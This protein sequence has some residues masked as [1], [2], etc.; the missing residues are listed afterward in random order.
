MKQVK[1]VELL[2]EG[3]LKL[4]L[5]S[6]KEFD[7]YM[8]Q[9][10]RSNRYALMCERKQKGKTVFYYDVSERLSLQELLRLCV[11]SQ[12]EACTLLEVMMRA[13][14]AAQRELPVYAA[15]DTIFFDPQ[16]Q[17]FAFVVLP[18]HD[19]VY[20]VDWHSLLADI[21][22]DLRMHG[23]SL[24]GCLHRFRL[25]GDADA[26]GLLECIALWKQRHTW[27]YR[28]SDTV[29][30]RAVLRQRKADNAQAIR[31]ELANKRFLS[32]SVRW[33][34]TGEGKALNLHTGNTVALFPDAA[35]GRLR[36]E[37]GQRQPLREK[38]LVGTGE[39]CDLILQDPKLSA[40]HAL[41]TFAQGKMYLCDLDSQNGTMCNGTPLTKGTS[42]VLHGGDTITLG[43]HTWIYEEGDT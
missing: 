24:Y 30:E 1:S 3:C 6:G 37:N 28:L 27:R 2:S 35:L 8:L 34:E 21:L 17:S 10:M 5:S 13:L 12:K 31:Q 20:E 29:K 40:H 39:D 23:D 11:L 26:Q 36:D 14:L 7:P 38:T 43:T 42:I 4:T 33:N 32:R 16:L 9:L 41:F 25:R 15:V 19:H 22:R 18:I